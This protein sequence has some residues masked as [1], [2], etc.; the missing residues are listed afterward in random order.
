MDMVNYHLTYPNTKSD[1]QFGIQTTGCKLVGIILAIPKHFCIKKETK[2]FIEVI[3]MRCHKKYWN[4]RLRYILI[5][6]LMRRFFSP[7]RRANLTEINQIILYDA[8][9]LRP[10]STIMYWNFQFNQHTSSQLPCSP[11]TPGWRRITSE[12]IPSA[13]ALINKWSSQFEI[14]QVFTIEEFSY[15]FM[16]QKH[17]FTYVVEGESNK[18]TDLVSYSLLCIYI[19]KSCLYECSGIHTVSS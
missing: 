6:E 8:V 11:R 17:V 16:L 4:N 2:L 7:W 3:I 14:R 12:D 5:K 10:V 1:W 15:V 9:L 13:L 18:I 19:S